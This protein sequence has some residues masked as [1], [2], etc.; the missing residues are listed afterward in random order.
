MS[1]Y[2]AELTGKYHYQ[3]KQI[4]DQKKFLCPIEF[5]DNWLKMRER[6]LSAKNLVVNSGLPYNHL[7]YEEFMQDGVQNI[8]GRLLQLSA[9]QHIHNS[10]RALVDTKISYATLCENY[11]TINQYL[12]HSLKRLSNG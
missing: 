10:D 6:Y 7:I 12:Q 3:K 2:Y 9:F 4:V 8:A 1:L 5:V 11:Q